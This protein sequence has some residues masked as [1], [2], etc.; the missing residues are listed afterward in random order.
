MLSEFPTKHESNSPVTFVTLKRPLLSAVLLGKLT[1]NRDVLVKL[2]KSSCLLV[3]KMAKTP[4]LSPEILHTLG[5]CPQNQTMSHLIQLKYVRYH[6]EEHF[7]KAILGNN[8]QV[9]IIR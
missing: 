2:T 7:I 6:R 4:C 8:N 5:F 3:S 9:N 1:N